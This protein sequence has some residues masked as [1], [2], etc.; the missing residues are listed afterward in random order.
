MLFI[1]FSLVF[2]FFVINSRNSLHSILSLIILFLISFFFLILL[3]VEFLAFSFIIV[4]VG[5][6]AVLFLFVIMMFDLKI[7]ENVL[8]IFPSGV[9]VYFLT[10]IYFFEIF[11]TINQSPFELFFNCFNIFEF[12][13]ILWYSS[14]NGLNNIHLIG[15]VLYTHFFIYFLMA[16]FILF[17][18]I[19]ASVMLTIS[20]KKNFIKKENLFLQISRK[21][22]NTFSFFKK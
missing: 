15:N 19:I 12:N 6:I 9:L 8:T 7:K 3:E 22:Y 18:A 11:L 17:I 14:I 1:L 13:Y 4:Y 2:S 10:F 5:A 16:G 20:F 21:H